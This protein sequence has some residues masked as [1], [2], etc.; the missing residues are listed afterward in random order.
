[1]LLVIAEHRSGPFLISE[2]ST[3]TPS[4]AASS[5]HVVTPS[6]L[7]KQESGTIHADVLDSALSGGTLQQTR[8][9]SKIENT[10]ERCD[11]FLSPSSGLKSSLHQSVCHKSDD[12][13]EISFLEAAA[14]LILMGCH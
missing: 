4:G 7:L 2:Q 10:F 8:G 12:A 6:R 5:L 14:G 11:E 13:E 9:S 1:M 3:P